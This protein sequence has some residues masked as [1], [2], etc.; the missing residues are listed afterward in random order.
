[1]N[2]KYCASKIS[3][4]MQQS[5][6]FGQ[7]IGDN[8][9]FPAMAHSDEFDETK[10]LQLLQHL[11]LGHYNLNTHQRHLSGGERQRITIAEQLMYPELLLL[12]EATSALDTANKRV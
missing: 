8:M 11:N 12:D 7:N 3:Y 10:A 4:L 2:Q 6:L 5:E 9:R 1:M